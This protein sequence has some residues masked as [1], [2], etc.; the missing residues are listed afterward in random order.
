VAITPADVQRVARP[1]LRHRILPNFA[2]EA[3]GLTAEDLI[4]DILDHVPAP[5]SNIRV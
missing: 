1:V 4:R 3:E 2:A 5:A